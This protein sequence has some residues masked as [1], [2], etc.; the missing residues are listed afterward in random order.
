M[1]LVFGDGFDHWGNV[2]NMAVGPY[3]LE[4]SGQL[5]ISSVQARTGDYS[6]KNNLAGLSGVNYLIGS[7]IKD[8]TI[9][10]AMYLDG[11]SI[12]GNA[13]GL[14][15]VSFKDGTSN[16]I[17]VMLSPTRAIRVWRGD[18][19]ANLVNSADGVFPFNTWFYLEARASIDN[20]VGII[21]IRING[22]TVATFAGDT[23]NTGNASF[24][25]AKLGKSYGID[26]PGL[27]CYY[28]DF[29]FKDNLNGADTSFF[30]PIRARTSFLTANETNQDWVP[31]VGAPADAWQLLTNV[32]PDPADYVAASGPGDVSSFDFEHVPNNVNACFGLVTFVDAINSDASVGSFELSIT[33]SHGTVTGDEHNANDSAGFY[34]DVFELDGG[35]FFWD[36]SGINTSV[37][38]IERMA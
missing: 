29:A 20:A 13:V 8:G 30:G 14:F 7:N 26:N 23:Q 37:V 22:F 4:D 3:Q 36:V 19:S 11:N 9:G 1:P 6:L 35:G 21:E 24:S 15:G 25:I 31:S 27:P 18:F 34:T 32:P 2:A 12:G 38:N 16:Q 10:V 28:D 17:L 33:N 5:S